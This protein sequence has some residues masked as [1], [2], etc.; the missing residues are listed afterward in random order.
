MTEDEDEITLAEYL[1]HLEDALSE[2]KLDLGK[3]QANL[4]FCLETLKELKEA[5]W[6][7][8]DK[9]DDESETET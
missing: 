6:T 7:S 4:H 5:E 2:I 9:M 1:E 8:D 3:A